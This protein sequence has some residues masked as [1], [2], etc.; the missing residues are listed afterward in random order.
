VRTSSIHPKL[1]RF[2]CSTIDT[3]GPVAV[4][5]RSRT[6]SC[7]PQTAHFDANLKQSGDPI[8]DVTPK[9]SQTHLALEFPAIWCHDAKFSDICESRNWS[10]ISRGISYNGIGHIDPSTGLAVP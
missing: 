2:R 6:T 1:V 10:P 8:P 9:G 3:T 7:I 4:R 5:A